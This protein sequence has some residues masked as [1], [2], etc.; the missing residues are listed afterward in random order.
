MIGF[1]P[2]EA[3]VGDIAITIIHAGYFSKTTMWLKTKVRSER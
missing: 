2:F 1:D 3:E